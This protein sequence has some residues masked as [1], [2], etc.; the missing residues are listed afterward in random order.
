MN[1]CLSTYACMVYHIYLALEEVL[2]RNLVL[3]YTKIVRTDNYCN[4]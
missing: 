3:L 4:N 1:K 2:G